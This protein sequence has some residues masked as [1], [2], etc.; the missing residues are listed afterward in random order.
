AYPAVLTTQTALL[1]LHST[2]ALAAYSSVGMTATVLTTFFIFFVDGVAAKVGRSVSQRRWRHLRTD[3]QLT[4]LSAG[5]LGATTAALF[6]LLWP[7]LERGLFGL[8]D[9]VRSAATPFWR[10]RAAM[11]PLLLLNMAC[12]GLLQ[13]LGRVDVAAAVRTAGSV[14]ELGGTFAVLGGGVE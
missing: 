11:V 2:A 9:E 7:G 1:G 3:V 13:G 5:A 10:L 4:F 6:A 8:A 14:L 12:T